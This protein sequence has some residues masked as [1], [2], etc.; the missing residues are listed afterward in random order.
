LLAGLALL[1]APDVILP[2]LI[3]GYPLAGLWFGQL[4]AA[5][6]LALANLN[7]LNRTVL[8]GGIYARPVVIANTVCYFVGASVLLKA[9]TLERRPGAFWVVAV[10]V[11]LF[12]GAY[13]WLFFRGPLKR[14]FDIYSRSLQPT[15][16]ADPPLRG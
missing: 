11:G 9:A 1:F 8:L 14:D 7:W 6:W 2:R 10:P 16:D 15:P 3:P 4:L 13:G 5:A 12:A